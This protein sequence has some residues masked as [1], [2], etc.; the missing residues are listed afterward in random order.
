LAV[1]T[2]RNATDTG[3]P[4]HTPSPHPAGS[5]NVFFNMEEDSM[6]TKAVLFDLGD[7]LIRNSLSVF[8]TFGIILEGEG[9]HVSVKEVEKA[10]AATE[11]ER[12]NNFNQLIG[13]IPSLEFY[14]MWNSRVIH[15]LEIEDDGDLAQK[16]HE[17]WFQTINLTAFPD[18][19]PILADLR[20]KGMKTGIISNAYEDEITEICE[21]VGLH[22][23]LFDIYVGSDTIKKAKPH[24]DIFRYVLQKLDI[25]PQE[26]IYVGDNIEKDYKAAERVGMKSLLIVRDSINVYEPVQCITTLTEVLNYLE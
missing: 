11:K 3:D 2:G 23:S 17:Q 21:D 4:F 15:A 25:K 1:S 14:Y 19:E 7:T 8:E 12:G 5:A 16:I 18:T 9:I 22:M 10:F 6:V 13:K 24:P 20:N 26:A